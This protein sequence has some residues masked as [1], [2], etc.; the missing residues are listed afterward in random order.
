M[1]ELTSEGKFITAQA[2][3]RCFTQLLYR[4][5]IL[6]FKRAICSVYNKQQALHLRLDGTS[7][8]SVG[9]MGC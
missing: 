4:L 6:D 8:I 1:S 5:N 2:E 3:I 9:E 7:V